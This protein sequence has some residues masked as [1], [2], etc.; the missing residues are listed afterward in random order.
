MIKQTNS[1][2]NSW[3]VQPICYKFPF[4]FAFI[5]ILALNHMQKGSFSVKRIMICQFNDFYMRRYLSF[6]GIWLPLQTRGQVDTFAD[7]WETGNTPMHGGWVIAFSYLYR[8][9]A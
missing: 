4:K 7:F 3:N 6:A 5:E 8:L 1:S 9:N 2:W